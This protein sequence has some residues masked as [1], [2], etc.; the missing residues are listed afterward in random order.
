PPHYRLQALDLMQ[1]Y[2]PAPTTE[3]LLELSKESS[4]IIRCRAA[5]LM[6]LHASKQ[7]HQRLI[8]MLDDSG[9]SVRRKACEALGRADQAPP[10]DRILTLMASDDRFEAWAARRI[11][12]RMPVEDWRERVLQAKNQRL[13]VQ[14]GL[15]L[16]ISHPTRDNAL[17]VL[18]PVSRTMSSFVSDRDFLDITR[19]VQVTLSRGKITGDDIPA[20]KRQLADEFPSGD[21]LM[22]RE[23]IRVL[24]F[25]QEDSIIDRYLAY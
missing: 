21:S 8:E 9:R 10:L 2:G 20:L 5:E 1:L 14:G 11:L 3:L 4:E 12:E 15:A 7:T 23:L 16:M 19:L 24:A 6:G 17:A 13:L 25:L 22:N 18:E